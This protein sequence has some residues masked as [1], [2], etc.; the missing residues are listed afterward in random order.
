MKTELGFDEVYVISKDGISLECQ[1]L[2]D[3]QT[4]RKRANK[5]KNVGF[6]NTE[7]ISLEYAYENGYLI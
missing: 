3:L 2:Y 1:C 6:E 7:V 4:A 5:F